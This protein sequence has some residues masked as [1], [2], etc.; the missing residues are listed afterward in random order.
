MAK[1]QAAPTSLRPRSQSR[2]APTADAAPKPPFD[3]VKFF[4][5]VR[6]EAR[7]V[8]WTSWKETW[9]TSVMVG[10]MVVVASVFFFMVDAGFSFAMN[11]VLKLGSFGS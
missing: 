1:D 5:E 10:I 2:T 3:P 6:A 4:R 7:K 9:I 8:T 11:Q